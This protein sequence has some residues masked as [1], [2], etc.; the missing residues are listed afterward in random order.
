M[1]Q[2]K[3]TREVGYKST[4]WKFSIKMKILFVPIFKNSARYNQLSIQQDSERNDAHWSGV[5][6]K[7]RG[8]YLPASQNRTSSAVC[9]MEL[10]SLVI[11]KNCCCCCSWP[12]P[13]TSAFC[14]SSASSN[15]MSS[16]SANFCESVFT[17][18]SAEASTSVQP[19]RKPLPSADSESDSKLCLEIGNATHSLCLFYQRF[20]FCLFSSL[21]VYTILTAKLSIKIDK[22]L[23]NIF[24]LR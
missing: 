7:Q 12:L 14:F 15:F 17:S 21:T 2:T 16:I 3:I 19:D 20:L 5:Y 11:R 23:L 13:T 4:I 22:L 9:W 6:A 24:T 1:A 8:L 10:T 18:I